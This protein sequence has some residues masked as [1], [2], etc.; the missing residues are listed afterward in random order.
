M[1]KNY[2]KSCF[3]YGGGLNLDWVNHS[4]LSPPQ[5]TVLSNLNI[6]GNVVGNNLFH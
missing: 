6:G 3:Y 5:L 2:G 1:G 4:I